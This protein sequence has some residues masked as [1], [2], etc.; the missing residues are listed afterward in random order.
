[1][2]STDRPACDAL[3][4]QL[5]AGYNA[6][7]T[8][9]R[10]AA[11]WKG[12][13]RMRIEA[14]ERVVDHCLGENG[15]EKLPT[16]QGLWKLFRSLRTQSPAV[17]PKSAAQLLTEERERLGYDPENPWET[18]ANRI[19]IKFCRCFHGDVE[20]SHKGW[21]ALRTVA[22][23]FTVMAA[24]GDAEATEANLQQAIIEQFQR[25]T[26]PLENPA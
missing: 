23:I 2:I 8:D 12:M 4:Q 17:Q 3:V 15:P 13:A 5:C 6:P 18:R 1:M 11:Y 21:K 26:K 10:L 19:G 20:L 9:A 14:F 16:S 7:P 24:D 25:I 22:Q